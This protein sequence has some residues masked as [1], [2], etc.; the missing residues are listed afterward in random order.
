MHPVNSRHF[1]DG[2]SPAMHTAEVASHLMSKTRFVG[3]LEA[4]DR[5]VTSASHL[6]VR[7]V[8]AKGV[9]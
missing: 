4:A 1:E 9:G 5:I 2:L 7:D 3:L 8:L 6:P